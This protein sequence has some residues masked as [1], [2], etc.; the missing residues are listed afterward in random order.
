MSMPVLDGLILIDCWEP[1]D[2]NRKEKNRFYTGLVQ[3]LKPMQFKSIVNASSFLDTSSEFTQ[4]MS[5]I[6][7]ENYLNAQPNVININT[8]TEFLQRRQLKPWSMIQNWLVVGTTWRV[9]THLNDMG[10]CS[11]STLARTH[12]E[13]NFYGTTWGFLR[14]DNVITHPE[15]FHNDRLQWKEITHFLFKLQPE[16]VDTEMNT[17]TMAIRNKYINETTH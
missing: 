6:L 4:S 9:C 17:Q 14:E 10:L 3:K 16:Q 8:Q 2:E 1:I 13:M 15:D 7:V 5:S 11:F 12:P